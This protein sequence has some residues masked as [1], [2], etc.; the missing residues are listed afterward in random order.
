MRW[1]EGSGGPSWHKAMCVCGC[2]SYAWAPWGP[3]LT[4]AD[5]VLSSEDAVGRMPPQATGERRNSQ[6]TRYPLVDKVILHP[7][8]SLRSGEAL[9]S[10]C[11]PAVTQAEIPASALVEAYRRLPGGSWKARPSV[12]LSWHPTPGPL[13]MASRGEVTRGNATSYSGAAQ[14]RRQ[15]P[16]ICCGCSWLSPT[17][18]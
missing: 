18:R 3:I 5:P 10:S 4:C 9:Q 12:S 13:P 6:L 14:L 8:R 2:A 1:R 11:G 17:V 15:T 16:L 7:C